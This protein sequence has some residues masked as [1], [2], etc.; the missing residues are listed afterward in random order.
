MSVEQFIPMEWGGNGINSKFPFKTYPGVPVIPPL[1]H[2]G[3][4]SEYAAQCGEC[5]ILIPKGAWG[6]S[7]PRQR[8]P[9]QTKATC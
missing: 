2:P 1:P 9:I 7:C 5:G 4:Y 6:Y 8:C 3:P